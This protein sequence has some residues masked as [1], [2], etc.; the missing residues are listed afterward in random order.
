MSEHEWGPDELLMRL[1]AHAP[2]EDRAPLAA[3]FGAADH[4][5]RNLPAAAVPVAI[6]A[7]WLCSVAA[8]ATESGE[9]Y[10]PALWRAARAY[11]EEATMPMLAIVATAPDDAR[12]LDA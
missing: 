10:A 1:Y 6:R 11:L 12:E 4:I 2:P 7:C 3:I 5:S 8:T 9:S